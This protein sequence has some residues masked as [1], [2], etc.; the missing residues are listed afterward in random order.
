MSLS[1]V[2]GAGGFI[3]SLLVQEL[4]KKGQEVVSVYN[5]SSSIDFTKSNL[6]SI[7]IPLDILDK[8]AL[9]KIIQKYRPKKIYHLAAQSSPENSWLDPRKTI[10]V[11]FIGTLN[12]IQSVIANKINPKIVVV[13]SS[14]VY[15]LSSSDKPIN[16]NFLCKP[17]NPYGLSKLAAEQLCFL[18]SIKNGV[19]I[20]VARPFF[21]IGP[22]K[23]GDVCSDWA[24]NIVQ[25]ERGLK[26]DLDV[27]SLSNIRDFLDVQDAVLALMTIMEKGKSGEVYNICSNRGIELSEI[28]KLLISFSLY[29]FDMPIKVLNNKIRSLDPSV[30]IGDNSKLKLLGWNH[31]HLIENTLYEILDYW[32]NFS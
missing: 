9:N 18:Y 16:E 1:L 4:G 12:L 14:S 15:G 8:N 3:G 13:S 5:T 11:N 10:N 21:I 31:D 28:S 23:R 32:R 2:T 7:S 20:S 19:S 17:N 25:I 26:K 6:K 27:G 24:R 22:R 30:L 29:N